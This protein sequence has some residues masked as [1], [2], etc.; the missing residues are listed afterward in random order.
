M[1]LLMDRKRRLH[2]KKRTNKPGKEVREL[3]TAQKAQECM[4]RGT[5]HE[6]LTY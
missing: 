3:I 6:N 4:S 5:L 2:I 1:S